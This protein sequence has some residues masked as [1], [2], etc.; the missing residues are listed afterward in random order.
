M[1]LLFYKTVEYNQKRFETLK[2]QDK[3]LENFCL[4]PEFPSTSF[5]YPSD[6]IIE[7]W[8]SQEI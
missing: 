2:T 4:P 3:H 5:Q 7:M 8:K 1:L 6:K